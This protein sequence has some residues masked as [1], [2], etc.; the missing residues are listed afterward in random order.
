MHD[1]DQRM[2]AFLNQDPEKN[3]LLILELRSLRATW[4]TYNAIYGK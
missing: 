2:L 1:W 3:A 4:K